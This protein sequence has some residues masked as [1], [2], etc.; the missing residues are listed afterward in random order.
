MRKNHQR[1][2]TNEKNQTGGRPALSPALWW[3]TDDGEPSLTITGYFGTP[4]KKIVRYCQGV[5][6]YLRDIKHQKIAEVTTG[7]PTVVGTFN[8]HTG[9]FKQEIPY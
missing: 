2:E 3:R 7:L 8:V 5:A 4:S 9:E 6:V 1:T